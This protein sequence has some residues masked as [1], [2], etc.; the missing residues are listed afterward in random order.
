MLLICLGLALIGRFY[1]GTEF[2]INEFFP[3]GMMSFLWLGVGFT[4][5]ISKFPE[6]RFDNSWV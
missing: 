4:F 2:E 5:Y 6:C 3:K 1:I